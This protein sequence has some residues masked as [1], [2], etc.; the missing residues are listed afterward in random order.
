MSER[1]GYSRKEKRE[2][3]QGRQ[4]AVEKDIREKANMEK[5]VKADRFDSKIFEQGANWFN[6][7]MALEDAPDNVRN[8][9]NFIRGYDRA[10]RIALIVEMQNNEDKK[11]ASR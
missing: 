5:M 11:G 6:E 2:I 4:N 7:G 9:S 1:F 3:R 8:N 10:K